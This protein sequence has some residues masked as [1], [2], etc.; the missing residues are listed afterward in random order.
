M[1][2]VPGMGTI[3]GRWASSQPM[4]IRAGVVCFL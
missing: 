2:F 4:A 1:R 3:H